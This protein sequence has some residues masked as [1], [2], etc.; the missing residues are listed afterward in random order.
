MLVS[1]KSAGEQGQ[2]LSRDD[3]SDQQV[4]AKVNASQCPIF[5]V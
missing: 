4:N 1:Q 5:S 3:C 2:T